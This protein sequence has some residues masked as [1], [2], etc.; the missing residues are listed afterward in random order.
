M[1]NAAA[2]QRINALKKEFETLKQGKKT[3]LKLVNE[4]ELF[5]AVYNSNAIENSTLSL[6]ETE[7]ILLEQQ[8]M[9]QV[10]VRELFEAKNLA[11][12]IEYLDNRQNLN[13]DKATILLLH[14]MLIGG[15]NDKIAGRF[16]HTD[17]YVR[18][19]AYIAPAPEHI[20]YLLDELIANYESAH[21]KY[22]LERVA[23]FHLEFE[24]IHP[25]FDGNG[26]V[27]RLLINLQLSKLGFPPII[28]RNKGKIDNYYPA[29][30]DFQE[31]KKTNILDKQLS[32]ALMESLNK[33]LA[34]LRSQK[35]VK[36]SDY[37]KSQDKTLNALINLARRQT[38]PAFREKGIW[39]IGV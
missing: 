22:F 24:R 32:L 6:A 11:R 21:E 25:F 36:L 2:I 30:R 39:K 15:I 20:A 26:R 16:R 38:I 28:I 35:I 14:K 13:L 17:E 5:E 9:R 23:H 37:S 12:V 34:Y 10:T 3:L 1:I 31:N 18:I 7:L 29:F 4:T 19:G 33:R 8:L 27:G